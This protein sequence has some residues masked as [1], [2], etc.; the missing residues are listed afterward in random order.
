MSTRAKNQPRQVI[1]APPLAS[2][3]EILQ[4]LAR[5]EIGAL[6]E[7]YD[8]YHEP[9]R[10]FV[11]R[12]TSDADD[13]DDL[14]QATFLEAARSAGRYDGRPCCRPWLIGIAAHLLRRRR[15]SFGRFL[16]VLSS[17]RAT[18]ATS[19]DPRRALQARGDVEKA[20][21]RISAAKRIALLM[22]EVEGLSC[23]EIAAALGIP[24]GTVWTR[25]HAARRELR[26][27]LDEGGKS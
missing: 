19:A 16:A 13:V 17:L 22:A 6:G 21:D 11:A 9:V 15:Q 23:A 25:L 24:I 12:A 20:L 3:P 26:R 5:G 7:L 18:R 1:A 27:A 2:D 10:R 8:R 4:E 14:V